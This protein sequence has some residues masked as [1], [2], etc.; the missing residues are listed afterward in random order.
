MY[1][2]IV[3]FH[4]FNVDKYT[5]HVKYTNVQGMFGGFSKVSEAPKQPAK[6]SGYP[7]V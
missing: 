2:L 6:P 5:I 7:H 1:V 4:G 3:D